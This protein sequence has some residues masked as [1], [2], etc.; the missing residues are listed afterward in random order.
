MSWDWVG[1][2]VVGGTGA[3]LCA[4]LAATLQRES[5]RL[6]M[7]RARVEQVRPRRPR[8]ASHGHAAH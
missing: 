7:A 8:D 6:R 3:A 2:L 4:A 5:A 1:L